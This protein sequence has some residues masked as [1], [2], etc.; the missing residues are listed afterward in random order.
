MITDNKNYQLVNARFP[1][2][3]KKIKFLWGYP[4]FVTMML[5]LQQDTRG[6]TRKGFPGEVLFA[7]MALEE[8]HDLEFP[9]LKR[10]IVSN[11]HTL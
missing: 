8:D 9:H 10:Q 11:W 5:K 2:I 6:G 1:H 3:G 4:E 7:L